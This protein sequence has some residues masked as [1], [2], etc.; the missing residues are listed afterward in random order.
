VQPPADI[1]RKLH[2]FG[3]GQQHAEIERAQELV[4]PIQRRSSTSTR[5]ISAIWPAGPP[6]DKTPIFA[7]TASATLK[8][9]ATLWLSVMQRRYRILRRAGMTAM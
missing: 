3:A 7:Q 2:G 4:S 1:G 8:D 5:C 6:N 9:G